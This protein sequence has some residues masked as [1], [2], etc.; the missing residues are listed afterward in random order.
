MCSGITNVK[1]K[2][3]IKSWNP[4][5]KNLGLV[6]PPLSQELKEMAERA[7]LFMPKVQEE[8]FP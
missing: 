2:K 4:P 3:N 6:S 8:N 5:K 1:I 7:S